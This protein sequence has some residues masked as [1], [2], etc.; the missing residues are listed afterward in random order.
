VIKIKRE[1]NDGTVFAYKK[2]Y[3]RNIFMLDIILHVF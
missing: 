3:D 2:Y 1:V